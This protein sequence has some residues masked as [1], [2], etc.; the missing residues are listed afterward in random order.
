MREPDII[1]LYPRPSDSL[2][3]SERTKHKWYDYG[4]NY[5]DE[6]RCQYCSIPRYDYTTGERIVETEYCEDKQWAYDERERIRT[7]D[8]QILSTAIDKVRKVLDKH[9][10]KLLMNHA[11]GKYGR[12]EYR[13]I[14]RIDV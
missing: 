11:Y 6:Y 5:G 7:R 1:D 12:V 10:F 9:E 4:T 2:K 8:Q 13:E 14:D 3:D